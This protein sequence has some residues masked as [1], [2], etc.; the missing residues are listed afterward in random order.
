MAVA[1]GAGHSRRAKQYS[2]DPPLSSG[3]AVLPYQSRR[4]C[5]VGKPSR[6]KAIL[7]RH[8]ALF[9][10]TWND[11]V[12]TGA[13]RVGGAESAGGYS[14]YLLRPLPTRAPTQPA[15]STVP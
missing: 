3:S 8:R 9:L 2:L 13:V 11:L 6:S 15:L 1:S 14:L 10:P 12:R 4:L 5:V 7:S